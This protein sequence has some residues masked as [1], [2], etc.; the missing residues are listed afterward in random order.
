MP[1]S[2]E[3]LNG[4]VYNG[5]E[6]KYSGRD[7]KPI[8]EF[9]AKIGTATVG[10]INGKVIG[11]GGIYPLWNKT[12]GAWLFLNREASI[13]KVSTFKAI[14]ACMKKTIAKYGIERLIVECVDDLPEAKN[15]LKHL[16]FKEVGKT[17]LTVYTRGEEKW[18][19]S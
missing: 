1:Y 6:L 9:Y 19:H 4:F 2:R 15:L 12:G 16:G 14:V 18:Q 13:H 11:V 17:I 7:I 3:I 10:I 8:V 5:P